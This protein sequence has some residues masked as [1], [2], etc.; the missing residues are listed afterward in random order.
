METKK[1]KKKV[2]DIRVE[3]CKVQS[4]DKLQKKS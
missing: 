3:L 4:A 1:K 2:R